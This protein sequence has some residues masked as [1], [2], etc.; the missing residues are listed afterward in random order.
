MPSL[1]LYQV[2]AFTDRPFTGNPAAVCPLQ[3]PLP[4]PLM[5]Q[6]AAENNLSETAFFHADG[7]GFALRW[8]T[9][10]VEVDL[11][12]HATLASALVLMDEL[13]RTRTRAV[14]HTRSGA[15]P[16][17]KRG[18]SFVLDLP[19]RPATSVD[20]GV[21]MDRL[22][23]ALGARPDQLLATRTGIYLAVLG[24]AADVLRLQPDMRATAE[25]GHTVC[26]TAPAS[27]AQG[28]D[29]DFVSR[30]FAPSHGIDEDPVTGSAH[31]ILALYWADRLGKRRLRARQVSARGG[32]VE[33]ELAGDRVL[34]AG[35]GRLVIKGTLWY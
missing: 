22:Q 20:D 14:F 26:A 19:A 30:Y 12:G 17:E 7:D 23:R 4:A 2:D 9:P 31:A 34:V 24:T 1:P 5:Q 11:C 8:F 6:I 29:V 10:T 18:D 16:V 35:Q 3:A 32:D 25:L 28:A 21:T 13:D 15:L 27:A 33:C